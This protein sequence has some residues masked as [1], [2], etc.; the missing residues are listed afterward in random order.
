MNTDN[1]PETANAPVNPEPT[2]AKPATKKQPTKKK[3]APKPKDREGQAGS[4]S[5][6]SGQDREARF[7]QM[8]YAKARPAD[9]SVDA[10]CSKK[11]VTHEEA[12]RS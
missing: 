1:T 11:G 3:A 10:V 8:A 7:A 2:Q 6:E 5:E 9:F 12:R 4:E